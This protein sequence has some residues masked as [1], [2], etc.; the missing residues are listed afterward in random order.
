LVVVIHTRVGRGQRRLR[1]AVLCCDDRARLGPR[2]C[3]VAG[4]DDAVL[5]AAR[6]AQAAGQRLG[7]A[8]IGGPQVG[9]GDAGCGSQRGE[10]SECCGHGDLVLRT[11]GSGQWT[12]GLIEPEVLD[13]PLEEHGLHRVDRADRRRAQ[14]TLDVLDVAEIAGVAPGA[15]RAA[16]DRGRGRTVTGALDEG[17]PGHVGSGR[18]GQER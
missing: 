16:D 6:R 11:G 10:R 3:A 9:L 14:V 12:S 5:A 17:A 18:G 4:G 7:R 8:R 15:V 13:V 2:L 1:D